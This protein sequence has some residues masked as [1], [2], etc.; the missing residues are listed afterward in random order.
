M[1]QQG[2]ASPAEFQPLGQASP[3]EFTPL[4]Q[5]PG[6]GNGTPSWSR[7]VGNTGRELLMGAAKGLG[8]TA[9]TLAQLT[10]PAIVARLAGHPFDIPTPS[11]PSTTAERI[12]FGGEQIAEFLVPIGAATGVLKYAAKAPRFVKAALRLGAEGGEMAAR[13]AAQGADAEDVVSA[14][15]FGAA[16]TPF[17]ALAKSVGKMVGQ[18]LPERLYGQVFRLAKD[19]LEHAYRAAARGKPPDPTLAKEV[20]DRGLFG[21][22]KNMAVYAYR[23]L[24]VLERELQDTLQKRSIALPKK[25]DFIQLLDTIAD[26]FGGTFSK[27]GAAASKMSTQLKVGV[28]GPYISAT[29]ALSLK[30]LLDRARQTSAFRLSAKLSP[31]QDT[32][33]EAAD[34]VRSRLHQSV[35]SA[36]R[37]L[38]EERIFIEATDAILDD[39]VR[40]EN[41]KL[42]GLT[43]YILGGGGMAAGFG[44]SGIGA[45]AAVRGFQQPFSLTGLGLFLNRLHRVTPSAEPVG[46]ALVGATSVA[47]R[48]EP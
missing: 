15:L 27:M 42:L 12:G 38:N 46:R 45:A 20:L 28:R 25:K 5:E 3:R 41:R 17:V 29:N 10:P 16:A 26:E 48:K 7:R 43:D 33:K 11:P 23:K 40:R 18:A 32:Y 8:T 19:D 34:L 21:S 35:P 1:P 44:V 39:A 13:T 9:S 36:S 24:D 14:G 6:A 37:L 47:T 2:M 22:S 30:R 4:V 31:K